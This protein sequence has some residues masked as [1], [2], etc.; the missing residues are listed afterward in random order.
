MNKFVLKSRWDKAAAFWN[1]E[2]GDSGVWHHRVDIDPVIFNLLG[3]IK[4]KKILEVGCGNGYL[5]RLLAR[6]GAEVTAVD[7][8]QKLLDYAILKER[9]KPLGINYL[10]R[11]ASNLRG[12]KNELFDVVVSNMSLMDVKDAKNAIKEI[13]RVLKKNGRFIFSINHPV[14]FHQ[15][16]VY[17]KK[18]GKKSFAK[19]ILN[20]KTPE[21][22]K[23]TLWASSVKV[24][25]YRRPIEEYLKYLKNAN[26]ILD[27]FKE[28]VSKK[29]LK[30]A[31][32]GHYKEDKFSPS[33]YINEADRELKKIVK[34]EIPSFLIIAAIKRS[35]KYD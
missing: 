32:K 26:L 25:G 7:L 9:K 13:S 5:S 11:S 12:I 23:Q 35:K 29:R 1:H 28:I 21:A 17:I 6:K 8:S 19:A 10:Q 34:K 14:F 30:K 24:M 20:Y 31:R 33:R 27:D 4:N 15:K 2:S 16:W 22:F 18:D 3:N